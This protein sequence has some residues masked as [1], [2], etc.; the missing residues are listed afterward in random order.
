LHRLFAC[1]VGQHF[2]DA[3]CQSVMQKCN[4]QRCWTQP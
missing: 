1:C 2:L 4:C 3:Q